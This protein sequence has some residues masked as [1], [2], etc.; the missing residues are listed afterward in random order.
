MPRIDYERRL[1]ELQ[2]ELLLLGS[3]VGKAVSKSVESLRNRD[4][5][6]AEEVI[7]EDDAIDRYRLILEDH[8][9]ELV[10]TQQPLATDLREVFSMFMI[11]S[12]LERMGDYAKGIAK[13]SMILADEPSLKPL[14]DIPRMCSISVD[15]INRSIDAF[16]N[17]DVESAHEICMADDE[18]DGL[19]DQVYRELLIL[20][21]I[22]PKS[23]ERAT[24]LLHVAHNLERTADRATNIA[25]RAIYVAT[26]KMTEINTSKY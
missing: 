2:Q 22:D 21:I 3:M 7:S 14:V 5:D 18:V 17:R 12:E 11:A 26:G 9:E 20:M 15:M 23:I 8:C 25:E 24:Y 1:K 6:L 10:A 4:T 16:I 19:H 13:I